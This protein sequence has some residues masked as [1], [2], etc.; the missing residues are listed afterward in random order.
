MP[1]LAFER[2]FPGALTNADNLPSLPA[3]ALEV[4]RLTQDDNSTIDELATALSRDPALAAKILKLSNSSLFTLGQEVTTLQ[5]ATMVLGLKTVKLMSLS[6]SLIGSIPRDGVVNGFDFLE[7]WRRSLVRSVSARS[8]ARL[9][10][11]RQGDEGFLCGLLAHFGRLVIARVLPD[12]YRAVSEQTGW[13]SISQEEQL[14]GFSSSDVCATMLREWNVPEIIYMAIG[15]WHR[16]EALPADASPEVA[17]LVELLE[18]TA[19]MESVL[20]DD[21]NGVP[22][23]E[24]HERLK[25]SFDTEPAEVDAFLIGLESGIRETADMLSISL[26]TGTTHEDILNQAKLQIVNVSLG[27]ALDLQNANKD[28]ARL[29]EEKEKLVTKANTDALTGLPNRG[30]FDYFL[31]KQVSERLTEKRPLALGLVM[32]DIDHFKRFNDEHGHTFGDE[33]LRVLAE[34]LKQATRKGDVAARYGGEEFAVIA[35]QTN[36]FNLSTMAERLRRAIANTPI[37]LDGTE[38]HITASFGAACIAEFDSMADAEA[39]IKLADSLMYR[40]K[41]NGRNRCE[42]YKKVRFPGR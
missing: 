22:L 5:R 17:S 28:R 33:V 30:F 42:T 1:V 3:V 11:S 32:L 8:L 41:D 31:E 9:I 34:T 2:E 36:P 23:A 12:E 27:T 18:L 10:G 25:D 19:L 40:A 14:L 15:Y 29:A 7:Y 13:P 38:V 21:E 39:L 35:P 26:P 16:P 24:L 20:C 37:M 6:F 4:L